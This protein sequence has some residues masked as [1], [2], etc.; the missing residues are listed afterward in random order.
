MSITIR[1]KFIGEVSNAKKFSTKLINQVKTAKGFNIRLKNLI[2]QSLNEYDSII[3]YYVEQLND[4]N[5]SRSASSLFNESI[6]TRYSGGK[7]SF[8][9]NVHNNN[10]KE[11]I[12][13]GIKNFIESKTT[14]TSITL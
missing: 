7:L 10:W 13:P 1:I 4:K 8:K 6:V 5:F 12:E 2:D 9:I 3:K 14:N 11:Y